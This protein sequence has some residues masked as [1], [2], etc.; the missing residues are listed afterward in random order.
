M[1]EEEDSEEEPIISDDTRFVPKMFNAVD[2]SERN[3]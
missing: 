1:F 2:S 3:E